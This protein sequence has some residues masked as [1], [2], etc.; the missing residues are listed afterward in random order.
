MDITE[1]I[2]RKYAIVV[3]LVTH[4]IMSMDHASAMLVGEDLTAVHVS[5]LLIK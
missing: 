5:E 1:K 2:V 4:V 3:I